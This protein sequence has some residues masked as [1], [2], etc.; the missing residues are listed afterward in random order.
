M[1]EVRIDHVT[2]IMEYKVDEGDHVN[3]GDL[4]MMTEVMKMQEYFEAPVSGKVHFV[5]D[6]GMTVTEG[7]L[8]YTIEED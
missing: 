4:V 2:V 5:S 6:L 1:K 8:L 3:A 7:D